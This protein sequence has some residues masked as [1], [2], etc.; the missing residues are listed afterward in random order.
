M[1]KSPHQDILDVLNGL[2]KNFSDLATDKKFSVRA[3]TVHLFGGSFGGPAGILA[4]RDPRVQKAVLFAPVVDWLSPSKAEPLPSL[5]RYIKQAFGPAYRVNKSDWDKLSSGRFYNPV[6]HAR[7]IDGRKLFFVHARDD[8]S[9]SWHSVE[10]FSEIVRA[11]FI[12]QKHGGHLSFDDIML[13]GMWKRISIFLK[14][15]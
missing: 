3:K 12:L 15:K 6:T 5:Y 8:E 14:E 11:R 4:S 10:K 7:E 9:V 2:S 1:K 13:P